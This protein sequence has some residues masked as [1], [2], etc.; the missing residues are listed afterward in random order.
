MPSLFFTELAKVRI[1]N[2]AFITPVEILEHCIYLVDLIF[3]PEMVEALL[4]LGKTDTV[5]EIDVEVTVGLCDTF[6]S[7]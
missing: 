5:V 6:E 4:E 7:L 1:R 2:I 3:D